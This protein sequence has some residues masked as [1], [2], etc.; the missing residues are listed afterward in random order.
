MQFGR[1]VIPGLV[2]HGADGGLG[3]AQQFRDAFDNILIGLFGFDDQQHHVHEAGKPGGGAGLVD[4]RHVENNVVVFAGLE[5]GHQR[6]KLLGQVG[7]QQ[8]AVGLLGGGIEIGFDQR[9]LFLGFQDFIQAVAK[10][11]LVKLLG[12][13][14]SPLML[15]SST[16][17]SPVSESEAASPAAMLLTPAPWPQLVTA[18][19]FGL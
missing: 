7:R 5:L 15:T 14:W 19:S 8:V 12:R 1:D 6:R 16:L 4:G 2:E 17:P 3:F 18:T 10:F 13:S 9:A 11:A